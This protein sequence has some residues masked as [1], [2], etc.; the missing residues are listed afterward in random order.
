MCQTSFQV[1][2]EKSLGMGGVEERVILAAEHNMFKDPEVRQ[3]TPGTRLA[4]ELES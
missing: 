2:K 1:A 4:K 3:S